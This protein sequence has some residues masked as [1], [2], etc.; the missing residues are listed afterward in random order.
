MEDQ[1]WRP[2]HSMTRRNRHGGSSGSANSSRKPCRMPGSTRIS[3][4]TR[5]WNNSLLNIKKSLIQIVIGRSFQ[6]QLNNLR[7]T[8]RLLRGSQV[9][10]GF[11]K[12]H[13][14]LKGM[15]YLRHVVLL[16]SVTTDHENLEALMS[17]P[18]PT[19]KLQLRSLLG[20]HTYYRVFID[21]FVHIAQPLMRQTEEKQTFEWSSEVQTA[22]RSLKE[23]L[24]TTR[25]LRY[26]Q[27]GKQWSIGACSSP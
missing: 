22:F 4:G 8:F 15:R 24:N 19:D 7:K 16:A 18:V 23:V 2:R 1:P 14:F 26:P 11:E 10:L 25:V 5:H 20:L 21:G 27:T 13:L 9:K 6:E 17:W 3:E 12:C